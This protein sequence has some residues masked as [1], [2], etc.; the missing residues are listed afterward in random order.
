[1]TEMVLDTDPISGTTLHYHFDPVT[2]QSSVVESQDVTA[3]IERNK[4]L[5][6]GPPTVSKTKEWE[7]IASIPGNVLYRLKKLGIVKSQHEDPWQ[8]SLLKWIREH[9]KFRTSMRKI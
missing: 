5:Q 1:M 2:E 4:R 9:P 6:A 7:L 8:R 3:L